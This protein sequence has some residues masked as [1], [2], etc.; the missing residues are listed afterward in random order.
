MKNKSCWHI[1]V[2]IS[3]CCLSLCT[4]GLVMNC[5]GVFY[6]PMAAELGVGRG[7]VAMFATICTLMNG[8]IAPFFRRAIKRFPV[9]VVLSVAI[10]IT[11][12]STLGISRVTSLWLLYLLGALQGASL[13]FFSSVPVN[14]L[15][16]NWFEKNHGLATGIAMCFSG[17]GGAVFSPIFTAA[18][19]AF[20]WR[21]AYVLLAVLLAVIALPGALFVVRLTPAERGLLPFGA[22][23]S[24]A[25]AADSGKKSSAAAAAIS[26]P[27]VI[28]V[29]ASIFA[30]F[31]TGISQHLPGFAESVGLGAATGATMVSACMLGNLSSKLFIG[32]LSDWLK[33]LK[34]CLV[35]LGACLI[36][37]VALLLFGSQSLLLTLGASYLVGYVYSVASVGMPLVTK[38]VFGL[39]QFAV[40]YPRVQVAT[41]LGS[42]LALTIIGF[43]YDFTRSYAAAFLCCAAF[44]IV[45]GAMMIALAAM[46]KKAKAAAEN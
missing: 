28:L 25:A 12:A 20:G 16:S 3:C 33:P 18:I 11:V 8:F 2:L 21:N 27:L 13:S 14:M 34:A 4:L 38:Y 37:V 17:V 40:M 6:S 32:I 7:S 44:L 35:M 42:A 41:S 26:L 46:R 9:N 31:N 39:E 22:Q 5:A 1:L 43:I 36:G 15:I 29:V 19:S 30:S 10:L 24:P 45:S 23:Q